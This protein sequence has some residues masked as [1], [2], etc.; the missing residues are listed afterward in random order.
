MKIQK[1]F[2]Y[3]ITHEILE[4]FDR[5]MSYNSLGS[6]VKNNTK[7]FVYEIADTEP[8]IKIQV[9]IKKNA[10]KTIGELSFFTDEF[11]FEQ[12]NISSSGK[13]MS[14]IATVADLASKFVPQLDIIFFTCKLI[15]PTDDSEDS[16]KKAQKEVKSKSV[17]YS[18]LS[19]KLATENSLNFQS[20]TVKEDHGFVL[21][22]DEP[23]DPK[24]IV[25]YYGEWA[26]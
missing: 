25:K 14:I 24:D 5:V 8:S 16:W 6:Y 19:K 18:R 13:A 23:I 9:K 1:I 3:D 10:G 22:K 17:I 20:F 11:G 12:L 15:V 7:F 26:D 2:P 21:S 4:A